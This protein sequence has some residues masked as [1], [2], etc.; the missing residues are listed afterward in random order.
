MKESFRYGLLGCGDAAARLFVPGLASSSTATL[1]AVASR[2]A[3][4]AQEYASRFSCAAAES[5]E[6]LLEREDV[7]VVY[8]GLPVSLHAE[9]ASRALLADKHVYCEKTLTPTLR[10]TSELLRLAESRGK[11]LAEGFMYRFHSLFRTVQ[12]MV[13]S[14][15]IGD[16]R[17]FVG[18]VGFTLPASDRVR[19]DPAMA[20]GVLNESGCYPVS[21]ARLLFASEPES[22]HMTR[23]YNEGVDWSGSAR[24]QFPGGGSAY[25][26][27]GYERSYR[28]SYALWGTGGQ[29]TVNRAYSTPA[30]F[31]PIIHCVTDTEREQ[32]IAPENHFAAMI[33]AFSEAIAGQRDHGFFEGEA[34]RQALT[35]EALRVSE[36]EDA[37]IRLGEFKGRLAPKLDQSQ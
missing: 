2:D 10:E 16:L 8:V 4:R 3:A 36:R 9:W 15:A 20:M 1:T 5:Y 7:D 13:G 33:D 14:G 37:L 22:V 17:S 21:A 32:R 12:E 24:L 11:R 23:V 34:Y 30:N 26:E 19:R 28:N 18:S 6:A 27:F 35:L 29:I 31:E 25:C